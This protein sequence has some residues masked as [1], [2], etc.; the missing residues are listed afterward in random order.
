MVMEIPWPGTFVALPSVKSNF[1]EPF[2]TSINLNLWAKTNN[3]GW[4]QGKGSE[5]SVL[6]DKKEEED[7][8]RAK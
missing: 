6:F 1:Q 5:M 3:K 8:V 4:G 7:R 2:M